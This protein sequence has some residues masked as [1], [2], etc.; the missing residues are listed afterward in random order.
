MNKL[1]RLL[2]RFWGDQV[3]VPK[4]GVFYLHPFRKDIGVT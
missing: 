3:V 4:E 1:Q 2:Q